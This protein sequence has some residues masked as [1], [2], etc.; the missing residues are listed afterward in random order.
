MTV[1]P[2]STLRVQPS[3]RIQFL[4]RHKTYPSLPIKHNSEWDWAE[5]ETDV[6]S[7]AKTA[8]ASARVISLASPKQ[9]HSQYKPPKGVQWSVSKEALSH[10][11]SERM[12]KLARP[13]NR[14]ADLED[15]DPRAWNVSVAALNAKATP[16]LEELATPIPRK[17]RTKK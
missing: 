9:S 5:W 6:N 4:A 2:T 14:N 13:K 11:A 8:S 7:A 10:V 3:E 12:L 1:I 15:Y 16:R 17:V